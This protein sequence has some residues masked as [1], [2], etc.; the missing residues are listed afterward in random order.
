MRK[1]YFASMV[2]YLSDRLTVP[3]PVAI[4][5]PLDGGLSK[6]FKACKTGSVQLR[7]KDKA[8]DD[9]MNDYM[10]S[11]S[12]NTSADWLRSLF[13]TNI[14]RQGR[15]EFLSLF[16]LGIMAAA[17]RVDWTPRGLNPS[18]VRLHYRRVRIPC[19]NLQLARW[20]NAELQEN[21]CTSAITHDD[22]RKLSSLHHCGRIHVQNS[23]ENNGFFTTGLGLMRKHRI[24]ACGTLK[25]L[26]DF[27]ENDGW[28]PVSTLPARRYSFHQFL[29]ESIHD[30]V[31][32]VVAR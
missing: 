6:E 32:S 12:N 26:E 3:S 14:T 31:A 1:K 13:P 18:E 7:L 30:H 4:S 2:F 9:H 19:A 20:I 15:L 23:K 25:F 8:V 16:I 28:L 24:P 5:F 11:T 27:L 10:R 17:G 21:G 22:K 29:G